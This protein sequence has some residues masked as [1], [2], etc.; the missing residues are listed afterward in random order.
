[1]LSLGEQQLGETQAQMLQ[2]G[3]VGLH[4]LAVRHGGEAGR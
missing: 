3:R 1:V 4:I 2:A